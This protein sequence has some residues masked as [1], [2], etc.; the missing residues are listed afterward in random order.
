MD[1]IRRGV[2]EIIPEE[3]LVQKIEKSLK[4]QKPLKVKLGCDPSRPDLHLGHSVVLRKLR[5]FQ[6]LGHQAILIVGDFTGMIGD[7]SGRSKTRPPLSLEETRKNGQSYFEQ[8]T[9]ILS[10]KKIQ[11]LYN[12]EWLGRMSFADV[13][14]LASKYT[15]ARMLERDD[16]EKRYKAGEPIS[17]HE[18][19][20]P[21]AQAMDSVAT[22][23][24]VELGGTD[25]KFN[26]L[27]GRDIQ[28]EYQMEPQ[29]AITLPILVGTDGVEKMSKSL[30]NYIGINE[31]PQEIYGKTL[32]IP[33]TL[34]YDYFLLTTNVSPAELQEIKAAL[35]DGRTNPRDLKRRL[36]RELVT[37]YHSA[38]DARMAQEEFDRI[39]VKKDLPNEIPETTVQTENGSIGIIDL[40]TSAKLVSSRGEARRMIEQGAVSINGV[41]VPDDKAMVAV[42]GEVVVKVGKR[43]FMRIKRG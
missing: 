11:M 32:S 22:E 14:A 39:F 40:L 3:E 16:F 9:K 2:A 4:T 10:T 36:A 17:I 15:V 8:A 7:P 38:E 24:D 34:I 43:K 12:S 13:I 6:D 29:V 42:R 5:Q 41:R 23:A 31:S 25:Q 26:L 30:D 35:E 20:Y 19:L 27:V 33:D 21:L 37:L 1:V 18:L 28:R